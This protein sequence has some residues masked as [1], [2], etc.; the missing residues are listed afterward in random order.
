MSADTK[1]INTIQDDIDLLLLIERG[2]SFFRKYKWIFIV[3]LVL[4]LLSGFVM[5]LILPNVFKSRLIVHSFIL[6][7]QEQIQLVDNW[8]ELLQKE[9]YTTLTADFNCSE[10]ILHSLKTMKAEEI[11]R[12]PTATNPSGFFIEVTV[13]N[14]A[15]LDEL[16]KGIIYGFEN[17]EYIKEKLAV[18]KAVLEE[19]IDKTGA[20]I[21]KLDS[22]KITVEN[23]LE[24]KAKSSSS[25][26]VDG[27]SINRQLIE[28]N[29]KLLAFKGELKFNNA[30]QVLQSFN[31]FEKPAG[32][33]LIP[34]FIIGL[35]VFLAIAFLYSVYRSIGEKLKKRTLSLNK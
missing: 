5:Y 24:G 25:L 11:Q 20:E 4:G 16:Q 28:M 31:K 1:N 13:T 33:K 12:L 2:L 3:A 26:I 17:C 32:P 15:I 34:W 23:I 22:A 35:M 30:V 7:N 18:R 8:N 27:S 9:E 19:L 14:N 10:K 6:T 29:E 21:Q